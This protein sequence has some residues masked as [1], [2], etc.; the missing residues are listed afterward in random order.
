MTLGNRYERRQAHSA[1]PP[2][3]LTD[4]DVNDI[5]ETA[6]DILDHLLATKTAPKH[7]STIDEA[8]LHETVAEVAAQTKPEKTLAF[9]ASKYVHGELF[10]P[11]ITRNIEGARRVAHTFRRQYLQA[12][13]HELKDWADNEKKYGHSKAA[14]GEYLAD[15]TRSKTK[16][17]L[18]QHR[19]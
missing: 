8:A 12:Q 14:I 11:D 5:G 7:T 10:Q 4:D 18:D 2:N 6:N 13:L 1:P 15:L 3:L 19:S 16:I 9:T 17:D